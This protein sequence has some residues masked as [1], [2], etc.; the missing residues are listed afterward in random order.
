MRAPFT[1]GRLH[2]LTGPVRTG[3]P[4]AW[5]LAALLWCPPPGAFAEERSALVIGNAKYEELAPLRNPA[6]DAAA[7]AE[8]LSGFGFE[9]I[10]RD[11]RTSDGPVLDVGRREFRRTVRAFAETVRRAGDV[12]IAFVCYAGRGMQDGR[13]SFLL[14]VDVAGDDVELALNE[15]LPLD[16]VLRPLDG[17]A[18]LTV[19]VFDACREIDEL[20]SSMERATRSSSSDGGEFRGPARPRSPGRSRLVAF[21]GAAGQLVADG[22]GDHSPYTEVL[23]EA[24]DE[25][26]AVPLE[27]IFQGV[28]YRFGRRHSGQDPELLTR[29]VEP[30]RF[31]LASAE[32][33]DSSEP[34][35]ADRAG[36]LESLVWRSA[37]RGATAEDYGAYPEQFP[38]A[39]SRA[40]HA[41]S[42]LPAAPLPELFES[43]VLI[44]L[45]P[46][47]S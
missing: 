38:D 46:G 32:T 29:G 2:P 8:R 33:D 25:K 13:R 28:A 26:A 30:N 44:R 43:R 37:E 41:S 11:D 3:R 24:L 1:Y 39:L 21:A 12:E 40:V 35:D 36:G 47:P 34:D 10:G 22:R 5:L 4:L 6:R 9:L 19:A 42:P 23:L 15:S 14:P 20:E 31:Y 27:D 17:H 7:V 18:G 16:D 45:R